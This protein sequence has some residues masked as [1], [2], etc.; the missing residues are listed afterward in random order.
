MMDGPAGQRLRVLMVDKSYTADGGLRSGALAQWTAMLS[1]CE[2]IQLVQPEPFKSPWWESLLQRLIRRRSLGSAAVRSVQQV[3]RSSYDVLLLIS[4]HAPTAAD[5]WDTWAK[6]Q[7][8][9]LLYGVTDQKTFNTGSN[10]VFSIQLPRGLLPEHFVP[11]TRAALVPPIHV[12]FSRKLFTPQVAMH[13]ST[14]LNAV[15][16]EFPVRL[17]TEDDPS[18]DAL[19]QWDLILAPT[20]SPQDHMLVMRAMAQEVVPVWVD[21][22]MTESEVLKLL[23]QMLHQPRLIPDLRV[24]ARERA[25][26]EFSRTAQ[27][28]QLIRRLR[29]AAGQSTPYDNPS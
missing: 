9:P 27:T 24:A 19:T 28:Q 4:E 22:S 11:V 3:T 10:P 20:K 7:G 16:R 18:L 13:V 12:G 23:R 29:I 6:R 14:A 17:H 8:I 26:M 25:E 5:P 1:G 21:E 2:D 15:V